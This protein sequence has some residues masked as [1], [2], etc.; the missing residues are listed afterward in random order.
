MNLSTTSSPSSAARRAAEDHLSPKRI[1]TLIELLVVIAIIAILAGMLLPALQKARETAMSA[2]CRSR[3]GQFGRINLMYAEAYKGWLPF[4]ANNTAY[5]WM[6]MRNTMPEFKTYGIS[7]G[8]PGSSYKKAPLLYC[9][10]LKRAPNMAKTDG[11][12]YYVWPDWATFYGTHRGNL[13]EL[14]RPTQKFLNVECYKNTSSGK[15]TQRYYWTN[16]IPF[17]HGNKSNVVHWDGHVNSYPM[18]LPYFAYSAPGTTSGLTTKNSARA[19]YHWNF[20]IDGYS[21]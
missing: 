3:I 13:K 2:S 16:Q 9:P 15:S 8:T 21:N 10:F 1:F 19:K 5:P 12:S 11:T 14:R 18:V 6:A 20:T 17:H 4:D 7:K